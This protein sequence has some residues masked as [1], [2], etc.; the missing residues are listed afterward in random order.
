MI[1]G[2]V[3]GPNGLPYSERIETR[4]RLSVGVKNRKNGV[5]QKRAK[6]E[7]AEKKKEGGTSVLD[8]GE[9]WS[10]RVNARQRDQR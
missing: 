3:P 8:E 2:G 4:R 10:R 6:G 1:A 5:G 9:R 7:V